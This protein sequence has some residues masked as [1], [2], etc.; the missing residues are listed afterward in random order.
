MRAE[1]DVDSIKLTEREKRMRDAISRAN[2]ICS[3][4]YSDSSTRMACVIAMSLLS[5]KT[6]D[7]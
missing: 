4:D 2:T 6:K 5:E 1:G 3:G 7:A